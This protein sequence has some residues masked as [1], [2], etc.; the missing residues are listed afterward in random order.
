MKT[1]IFLLAV[2]LVLMTSC[3]SGT[4]SMHPIDAKI[5]EMRFWYWKDGEY[6]S[7]W[8]DKGDWFKTGDP[9]KFKLKLHKDAGK[10]QLTYQDGD[11][12]FTKDCQGMSEF[13]LD[14]GTYTSS[15]SPVVGFSVATE[16]LGIQ[17]GFFYPNL[18]TQFPAIPVA[19]KCPHSDTVGGI[20]VC[21]RPATYAFN[22][23]ATITD[24][25]PGLLQ[26]TKKCD[27]DFVPTVTPITV[28]GAGQLN[29]SVTSDTAQYCAINLAVKQ[30]QQPDGSYA[31]KKEQTVHIRFYD[32]K[33]VPLPIPTMT[34]TK[35]GW[36]VCAPQEYKLYSVNESD[37]GGGIFAGAC[38]D[39]K[40]NTVEFMVWDDIGRFS[41]NVAPGRVLQFLDGAAVGDIPLTN[42]YNFYS[43][44]KPWIEGQL[45]K[46]CKKSDWRCRY[47]KYNDVIHLP[48]MIEAVEKWDASVLYQ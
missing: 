21:T 41:W 20:S 45:D 18:L 38:Q 11:S 14:L 40:G 33:Y 5:P 44:A 25:Y 37:G 22:F 13:E 17:Q 24:N 46:L 15:Q 34:Q 36:H 27:N 2:L 19:Y 32:P 31:I 48:K 43:T 3:S 23:V 12:H 35:D 4:L 9:K 7:A 28:T 1:V 10:C 30:N 16:N 8:G 39:V 6:K 42:G 26:F 47:F 29:F